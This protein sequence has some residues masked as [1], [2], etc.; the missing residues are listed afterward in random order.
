MPFHLT[1]RHQWETV[2]FDATGRPRPGFKYYLNLLAFALACLEC[3]MG[4]VCTCYYSIGSIA[5]DKLS[6]AQLM[7]SKWSHIVFEPG[8]ALSSN[9]RERVA[10]SAQGLASAE[11]AKKSQ[12]H[13][14]NTSLSY[15]RFS[16]HIVFVN[17]TLHLW[18]Q[19]LPELSRYVYYSEQQEN[20][21]TPMMS[22]ILRLR[23]EEDFKAA[24][25]V[26][27]SGSSIEKGEA[28]L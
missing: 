20:R 26:E 23:C 19:A 7:Y 6:Q 12:A 9:N 10:S 28:E 15:S 18:E 2:D 27:F 4:G 1:I 24:T 14:M 21:V 11:E 22:V 17:L 13:S 16:W 25:F 3:H 5:P 8:S